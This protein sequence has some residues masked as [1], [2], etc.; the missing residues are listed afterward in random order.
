MAE[1]PSNEEISNLLK[2]IQAQNNQ[3][4]EKLKA[5]KLEFDRKF[6]IVRLGRRISYILFAMVGAPF[7]ICSVLGAPMR[8][9][10]LAVS[11]VATPSILYGPSSNWLLSRLTKYED[12]MK[13]RREVINIMQKR[14]YRG[15]GELEHI[16]T[17]VERLKGTIDLILQ[18]CRILNLS[19]S[20]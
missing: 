7:F 6:K 4:L 20:I 19:W 10:P 13:A 3:M 9:P 15:L 18:S 16:S 14:T 11:I 2:S 17:Y 5:Q 12:K 1:N 8:S